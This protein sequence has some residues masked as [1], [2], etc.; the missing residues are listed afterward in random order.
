MTMTTKLTLSVNKEV[1]S[2]A[3]EVSKEDGDSISGIFTGYIRARKYPEKK[4]VRLGPITRQALEIG[5]EMAKKLPKDFNEKEAMSGILAK[6]YGLK[7]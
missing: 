6:K 1:V 5:R 7:K 3:R 4:K 2:W